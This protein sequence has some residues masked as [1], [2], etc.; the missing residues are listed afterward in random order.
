M[1]W[2]VERASELLPVPYDHV[3]FTIPAPIAEIV[4]Q[5]KRR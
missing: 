3:V 1:G 5:K 4:G 2:L